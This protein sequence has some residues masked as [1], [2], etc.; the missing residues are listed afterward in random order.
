MQSEVLMQL[1]YYTLVVAIIITTIITS[2]APFACQ[3]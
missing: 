2:L 3:S 1:N